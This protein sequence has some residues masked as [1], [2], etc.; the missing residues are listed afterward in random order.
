MV[1]IPTVTGA[2]ESNQIGYTLVHEHLKVR[3][4]V[5]L[6]QFPQISEP[7]TELDA[8][9]ESVKQAY[10]RGIQMICDCTI[11]GLGRDINFISDVAK[12]TDLRILV[13]TGFYTLNE[14]PPHF[15]NR[16]M[17]YMANIFTRE[18]E[19]GIQG[20]KIKPAFLKCCTDWQGITPDVEK[21]I[22]AV[23]R[24]HLKTGVPIVTH[25]NPRNMSG[26][27][28]QDIFEQEGVDLR[29]VQIGHS[30]DTD[31]IDYLVRIAKR[32]SFLGMDRYGFHYL[33]TPTRNRVI[34]QMSELGFANK[35]MLSHDKPCI[36]D[37]WTEETNKMSFAQSESLTY[38]PDEVIPELKKTGISDQQITQMMQDNVRRWFEWKEV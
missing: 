4:E 35:M 13:G 23:A 27:L 22:R 8:A 15:R 10:A 34:V 6:F 12:S 14:L 29:A 3:Y 28:Q 11:P 1:K 32:G 38:I 21:T 20:T 33:S 30:G 2:I 7:K 25:S 19:D 5:I 24:A 17:D 9:V 16:S 36:M 37:S 18:V 26:L 31:N